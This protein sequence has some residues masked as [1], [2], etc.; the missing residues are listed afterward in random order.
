MEI[1]DRPLSAMLAPR[2]RD[3]LRLIGCGLGTRQIADDLGLS[4]KTIETYRERLKAK[5]EIAIA[6]QLV[7]FAVQWLA[8]REV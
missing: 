4:V 6:A 5:L 8:E 3:V 1:G 2:E 7:R